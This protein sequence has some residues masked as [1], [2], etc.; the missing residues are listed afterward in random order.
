VE[1][2]IATLMYSWE[3]STILRGFRL[4]KIYGTHG[5]IT[6]ESDGKFILIRGKKWRLRLTGLND[7][8][9]HKAM[10]KDFIKALREGT[11]PEFNLIRAKKD[12]EL[13]EIVMEDLEEI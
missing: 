7:K 6:F 9:G 1:G 12:L 3:V 8:S 4:S 5:S 13:I 2:P 11:E 10:F